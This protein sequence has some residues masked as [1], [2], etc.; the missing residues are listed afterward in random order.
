MLGVPMGRMLSYLISHP[1]LRQ[2]RGRAIATSAAL[3]AA[4]VALLWWVPVPFHTMAQGVVWLP[5]EA[6]VRAGADGFIQRVVAAPDRV[7]HTG[8]VLMICEHPRLQADLRMLKARVKELEAR[9][10]EQR[11]VDLVKAAIIQEELTY[12]RDQLAR[13][14]RRTDELVIRSRASGIFVVSAPNDLPGRFIKQ[15]EVLA[16]VVDMHSLTVR[17]VV[18]QSD[19]NL[20]RN[21]HEPA[22]VR[23]AERLAEPLPARISRLMPAAVSELPSTALGTEG[24][25]VVPVDP[26]DRK[27]LKAMR[28][29]FHVDLAVPTRSSVVNAGGRV[30]IRFSHEWTPLAVQWYRQV[31]QLFL[32]R[33]NV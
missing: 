33:F 29:L 5:D 3:I 8:D 25:G 14:Q 20:I 12:A 17:A 7:V 1:S 22:S 23:L 26:T 24:G 4:A 6:V 15:G 16:H 27:G 32:S 13:V 28:S 19:I 18:E 31:R 2:V 9:H 11:P 30:Y 21:Q 10:A